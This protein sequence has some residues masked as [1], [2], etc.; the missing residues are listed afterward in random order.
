MTTEHMVQISY[1]NLCK[2]VSYRK[3]QRERCIAFGSHFLDDFLVL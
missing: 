3:I 2:L 1:E